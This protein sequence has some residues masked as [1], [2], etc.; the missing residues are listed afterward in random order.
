MNRVHFA[1]L[2]SSLYV[3]TAFLLA[4]PQ[5]HL[6]LRLPTPVSAMHK[7]AVVTAA[8][9]VERLSQLVGLPPP[10][11]CA[12]PPVNESSEPSRFD[13][14]LLG[15]LVDEGQPNHSLAQ[16]L[17]PRSSRAI[18]YAVGE[19]IDGAEIMSIERGRV[20]VR[21]SDGRLAFIE[22]GAFQPQPLALGPV[23]QRSATEFELTR[24]D[25]FKAISSYPTDATRPTLVPVHT[26]GQPPGV[27]VEIKPGSVFAT[28]GLQSG[29]VIRRINGEDLS[30]VRSRGLEW[31]G[32]LRSLQRIELEVERG[33][34][35][36]RHGYA[37]R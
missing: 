9:S 17:S 34:T 13:A 3:F 33:G 29:D 12:V 4:A 15:T 31:V 8:L 23:R 24:D 27:R 20:W 7:A 36:I 26:Q 16:M 1:L 5:V 35:V 2:L 10:C 37:L 14:R 30:Q 22:G 6:S 11:D 32:R 18:T 19:R 21:Q 28:L 25:L